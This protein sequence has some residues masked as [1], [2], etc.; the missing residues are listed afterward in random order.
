MSNHYRVMADNATHAEFDYEQ[1]LRHLPCYV[2]ILNAS[3]KII[4][5]NE[6]VKTHFGLTT[7]KTCRELYQLKK[8]QCKDCPVE[9]SFIDGLVHS[10]EKTLIDKD[11]NRIY[12]LSF[13]EPIKDESG[14][15]ASVVLTSVDITSV[16]E[17]QKQLI[18]LGQTVA[19]MAHSIKN[20]MM[21]LEGGIYVVNKGIEDDDRQQ[22]K[23]GWE[24]VLLNFDKISNIVKDILYC[25]K[26]R[27][28]N[29]QLVDPNAVAKEVYELFK[30]TAASYSVTLHLGLDPSLM[31][32]V[33]DPVGLHTV[34]SNLVSNAI[35][36]CKMDIFK[37][38]HMVEIRS[39]RGKDGAVVFEVADNGAGID[40]KVKEHVFED[41]FSSKGDKGTGLGLM[42][43]QKIMRE[44][45]GKITFRSRPRE[46]TTFVVTFPAKNVQQEANS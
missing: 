10:S 14:R 3:M 22:V 1:I 28:P 36:A 44:H 40:R 21:G 11:G 24:M 31:E 42:V 15:V 39:K 46:G 5:A 30:S 17:L 16:K 4:W 26:E 18:L 33:I 19:G 41:F 27:P 12:A 34:L 23:E 2:L 37:D 32:A 13:S 35:D 20:I 29:L 9:L 43:T 8:S 25:S 6:L 7:A 38:E 45:G